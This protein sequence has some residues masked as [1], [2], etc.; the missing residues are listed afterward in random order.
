MYLLSRSVI[1]GAGRT[2]RGP[3]DHLC[4]CDDLSQSP[5]ILAA[6]RRKHRR[7]PMC[8]SRSGGDCPVSSSEL[9][10]ILRGDPRVAKQ[11]YER[12]L[13]FLQRLARAHAPSLARDLHL[14]IVQETWQLF[15][16]RRD[17]VLLRSG[18]VE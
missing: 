16:A 5:E 11:A 15:F 8:T 9:L 18:A 7:R 12:S 13:P 17:E 2:L 3:F 10:S 14:E 1:G 6:C 4:H